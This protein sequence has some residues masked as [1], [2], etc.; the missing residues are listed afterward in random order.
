MFG[1]LA[2]AQLG[3]ASIQAL[4][5][6]TGLAEFVTGDV[7]APLAALLGRHLHLLLNRHHLHRNGGVM[8]LHSWLLPFVS[9]FKYSNTLRLVLYVTNLAA[10]T[11]HNSK[12]G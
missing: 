2:Y 9:T 10:L 8:R 5:E 7:A 12:L 11:K 1:G 4:E 6:Q 3:Q